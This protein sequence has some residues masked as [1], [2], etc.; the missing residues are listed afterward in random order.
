MLVTI[1]KKD[2]ATCL[3]N[4]DLVNSFEE[5]Y[6]V[7]PKKYTITCGHC[8]PMSN[9][10]EFYQ[11]LDTLRFFMVNELSWAVLD[12]IG[13]NGINE[14]FDF[15]NFKDF[16]YE[17][18]TFFSKAI[19][20][21]YGIYVMSAALINN[22]DMMCYLHHKGYEWG[23]KN[24]DNIAR[25]GYLECLQYALTVGCFCEAAKRNKWR[26]HKLDC[27]NCSA[28]NGLGGAAS[29][30]HLHVVKYLCSIGIKADDN[31]TMYYAVQGSDNIDCVKYLVEHGCRINPRDAE[32]SLSYGNDK[33]LKYLHENGYVYDENTCRL[34][35]MF[36]N[37]KALTYLHENNT[38][39]NVETCSSAACDGQF[40]CLKYAHMNGCPWDE[41]TCKWASRYG[42]F[43]CLKYAIENQCPCNIVECIK[44]A[45]SNGH[46]KIAFYLMKKNCRIMFNL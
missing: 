15:E 25:K 34:A 22:V 43:K 11:T 1:K 40:K 12:Y 8:L 20:S 35:A 39:W 31:G 41:K 36:G 17:E 16:Y 4:S 32:L 42:R 45:A 14:Q 38:P 33:V 46:Y 6:V 5:D 19:N 44:E 26:D 37:V 24:Y 28:D 21:N 2:L 13:Y 27:C 29:K 30:G 9:K 18:L 7:I 10:K 23:R 3:Q